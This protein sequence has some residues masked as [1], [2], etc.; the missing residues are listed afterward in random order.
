V[1]IT[2]RLF[3]Y[4]KDYDFETVF[5]KNFGIIKDEA[6]QIEVEFSGFAARYVVER[7]WSPNQHIRYTDDDRIVL[8]FD[9][10]SVPEVISWLLSF[11][12]EG[13][14]MSPDWLVEEVREKIDMLSV[15][16]HSS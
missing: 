10:T 8:T 4:P 12:E 16:Y 11:G 15:A 3:E 2:D 13:K 1:E 14:L 9:A 5:N 6:F 7:M